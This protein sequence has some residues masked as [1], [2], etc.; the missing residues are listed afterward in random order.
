MLSK[1]K[2]GLAISVSALLL[3]S[4]SGGGGSDAGSREQ[5]EFWFWGVAPKQR[6]VLEEQLI[7][8]Y[9][10]SQDEFELVVTYNEKVDGN[11]QTAL[12]ANGG[13]DIV[14]GSGPAFVT[15]YAR[16]G[17][18]ADMTPYAEKY[19]WKDN[20]LE[21]VYAAGT[22]DGKLYAMANSINTIG[23][24]YN[25][26]VLDEIGAEIPTDISS[27]EDALEKADKAGL[28]P[29]VTGNKGWQPVN[30]NYS[31]MFFTAIAGPENMYKVLTGESKWT[32]EPYLD[33]VQTSADWYQKGWLGGGQ[34]L[35]LNFSESMQ[36]LAD[37]KSPFFFGP[38][39]AFQFATDFF[40]EEAGNVDALGFTAFPVI[41][42]G[43]P[44]P[45]YTISTTASLSINANSPNQD[46]AA[47][48]IDL[49]MQPDFAQGMTEQWPGY[50]AV[51]LK[52]LELSGPNMEGLSAA[53]AEAIDDVIPAIN[54]GRFGYFTGTF[55]PAKTREKLIDIES[56]WLG[57]KTAEQLLQE[58][59]SLFSNELEAGEVP[60]IPKP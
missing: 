53:Y 21:A 27:L 13:P 34:Y 4:C 50:W 31:S 26:E 28:Y 45:L 48:I 17:K 37:G 19:G 46:E 57:E 25:K 3:A 47:H 16:S 54:D 29:S 15:P 60:P 40:N 20:I 32:D 22:V 42:D 5:I 10:E 35:N 36:L 1:I 6:Q 49:M 59:E 8:P 56:V 14:Y 41:T 2:K 44:S 24:F 7:E 43:L 52:D 55:F 33:A 12:A 9:N 38:T 18:L 30:E 39:L 51:P 58:T 23:I 11:I